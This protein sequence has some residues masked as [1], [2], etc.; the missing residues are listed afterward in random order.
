MVGER[1][2]V[3]G[4]VLAFFAGVIGI[5][6]SGMILFPTPMDFTSIT[7]LGALSITDL[8]NFKNVLTTW[9]VSQ[10][11]SPALY[12]SLGNM[13]TVLFLFQF[14][15]PALFESYGN[16]LIFT[17]LSQMSPAVL[18]GGFWT[19]LAFVSSTGVLLLS[20]LFV[21]G[22][23]AKIAI[24]SLIGLGAVETIS[25]LFGKQNMVIMGGIL[26]II[27]TVFGITAWSSL[28]AEKPA[29]KVEVKKVEKAPK[30][31]AKKAKTTSKRVAVKPPVTAEPVK[32]VSVPKIQRAN[33]EVAR[34]EGVGPVYGSRLDKE[35]IK[36]IAD[37]AK[38]SVDRVA[39]IAQVSPQKA[40]KWI[41]MADILCLDE[42]DQN[43]AELLVMGA[44]VT[45]RRDLA[46]KNADIL[47][48]QMQSA[49]RMGKV[50]LPKGWS[51]TKSDVEKWINAAKGK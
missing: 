13:L 23:E 17:A 12:A 39:S 30:K 49:L 8:E 32:V 18:Y 21:S 45:S 11:S 51:F 24:M 44:G 47:Y 26:A 34:I 36:T 22:K 3:V 40:Q 7:N 37:L 27:A 48:E 20:Y 25:G 38:A 1:S 9:C 46:N 5:Y 31:K 10:F 41:Q 15:S 19:I 50:P 43:A 16:L 29:A 2:N 35:G 28:T 33:M 14:S 42:V 6:F 4:G